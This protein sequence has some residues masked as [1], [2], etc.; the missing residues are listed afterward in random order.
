MKQLTSISGLIKVKPAALLLVIIMA[1]T[2]FSGISMGQLSLEEDIIINKPAEIPVFS[3]DIPPVLDNVN[4][5]EQTT[6]EGPDILSEESTSEKSD[7][8][9]ER[10]Y[11]SHIDESG[12]LVTTW[13]YVEIEKSSDDNEIPFSNPPISQFSSPDFIIQPNA[14]EGKDA[15]IREG[16][17][18]GNYGNFQ[19]LT[20]STSGDTQAL[21]EF[22]ITSAD[23]IDTNNITSVEMNIYHEGNWAGFEPWGVYQVNESWN[24]TNVTWNNQP[25]SS[26]IAENINW[27]NGGNMQWRTWN[28]TDI[29]FKW[30]NG[31]LA[32]NG[33]L[34]RR[35]DGVECSIYHKSSDSVANHPFLKISF[36]ADYWVNLAPAIQRDYGFPGASVSYSLTAENWGNLDETYDISSFNGTWPITFRDAGDTVDITE[37]FIPAGGNANFIARVDISGGA[38]PGDIEEPFIQLTSQSNTSYNITTKIW[39]QVPHSPSITDDFEGSDLGWHNQNIKNTG[40]N[41]ERGDPSSVSWAPSPHSSSNC[42]GTNL[43]LPVQMDADA[44]LVSPYMNLGAGQ[45]ILSFYQWYRFGGEWGDNGGFLEISV[46]GGNW[47]MIT[48]VTGYP[49]MNRNVGDYNTDCFYDTS[50]GWEYIECDLTLYGGNVIQ[51]RFHYAGDW[52]GYP[53]W[54]VDDAYIGP[55]PAYRTSLTP[56][57]SNSYGDLGQSIAYTMTVNNTGAND[58]TYDLSFTSSEQPWTIEFLDI[59]WNPTIT[60]G[61]VPA[62][63]TMDF[64]TVVQVDIGGSQGDINIANVKIISQND[65]TAN[66]TAFIQTQHP[67]WTEWFDGFENGWG[68]WR[69]EYVMPSNPETV[70]EVGV[71]S[72]G[73]S[74]SVYNGTNCSGTN[75]S[76]SYKMNTNF[77]LVSPFI[78]I[79]SLM[80]RLTFQNWYDMPNQDGGFVELSVNGGAWSQI[81]PDDG[82][83]YSG[84]LGVYNT[85]G[86]N[87]FSDDW[88]YEEFNL[89]QYFDQVI[90]VRFHFASEWAGGWWGWAIDDVFIGK[91]PDY[92]VGLAP[93]NQTLYGS[94]TENINFIITANNTGNNTD[95]YDL[96][97]D[98]PWPLVFRDIG[99]TMDITSISVDFMSSKEFIARVTIPGAA[100]PGQSGFANITAISQNDPGANDTVTIEAIVLVKPPWSDDME[101]GSDLWDTWDD[102]W[103][104]TWDLGVPSSIWEP[105]SAYSPINCWGTNIGSNYTDVCD[106]ALTSPMIDLTSFANANLTFWHWYDTSPG[107][108]GGWVEVSNDFGDNWNQITPNGGYPDFGWGTPLYGGNS[109]GWIQAEFD[110][111]A[112]AGDIISIRFYFR[113]A[114]FDGNVEYVGWY[115]DDIN[116][117][118]SA[119][120]VDISPNLIG[121]LGNPGDTIEYNLTVTNSGVVSDSFDLS[122]SGNIWTTQIYDS[123]GLTVISNTGPLTSNESIDIVVKVDIPGG[124]NPGEFDLALIKATSDNDTL[125]SDTSEI[126]TNVIALPPWFD[127]M[128]SGPG[129]WKADDNAM[130]TAWEHGDPTAFA[131]GP[132]AAYSPTNCWGTNLLSNYSSGGEA[133]LT[134]PVFNISGYNI[135]F[136][137]FWHWYDING[138]WNDGGRVEISSNYGASWSNLWPN[139]GYTDANFLG[140]GCYA[141][142]SDGWV[143]VEFDLTGWLGSEIMFRFKFIDNSGD[144]IECAG[145]YIDNVLLHVTNY[146]FDLNPSSSLRIGQPSTTVEFNMNLYV[147][148]V[149]DSYDL[150]VNGNAWTTT[151]YDQSGTIVISNTGPLSAGQWLYFLVRVDIPGGAVIND[152]DIGYLTATSDNDT[153]VSDISELKTIVP[154]VPPWFDDVESG[155]GLWDKWDS[156]DGTEWELGNPSGGT[157]P[158]G[159]YSPINC[160][161]TNILTDYTTNGEAIL[162]SPVFD[163]STLAYA[164]LSFWHWYDIHGG[165]NDGGWVEISTDDNNWWQIEPVGGYPDN[166]NVGYECYAG[167]SGGWVKAEFDLSPWAHQP[168]MIRFHFLDSSFDGT[169][170]SGWYIDDVNIFAADYQMSIYP[171]GNSLFLGYPSEIIEIPYVVTNEATEDDSY[172]LSISGNAWP[173]EIYDP[174]GTFIISNTGPVLGL[175]QMDFILKVTVPVGAVVRDLD[176]VTVFAASDNVSLSRSYTVEVHV[177]MSP[178]FFDDMESGM[179]IW[180]TWDNT[181]GTAWELGNPSPWGPSDSYSPTNCWGTNIDANYTTWG[182]CWFETPYLD[183]RGFTKANLTFWHWYD[184]NGGGNDGGWVEFRTS[185]SSW[186][187]TSPEGD[188]P[189]NHAWWYPAF[190]GTTG[191][192]EKVEFNMSSFDQ[193]VKIRFRF[194][195]W[196]GDGIERPGWYIDDIRVNVDGP[197]TIISTV[198]TDTATGVSISQDISVIYTRTMDTGI[199]PI[200]SQNSVPDPGGWIFQ[201]WSSTFLTDDTATWSHNDWNLGQDIEMQISGGQDLDAETP[202]TYFWNFT[203]TLVLSTA[204]AT[205]PTGTSNVAGITITYATGGGPASADIYYTTSTAAPYIWNLI[206]TDSPADGNYGWVIPADGTYGWIAVSPDEPAPTNADPPEASSYVYDSTS[207]TSSVD[208][209][210]LEFYNTSP[211]GITAAANDGLSGIDYVELWYSFDG[212]SY[213]LFGTDND[214]AP[215]DWNFNWPGEGHYEFYSIAVDDAGNSEA[216]PVAE[217][218]DANYDIT[219]PTIIVTAPVDL[220]VDI[221]INLPIVITFDE[222]IDDST[223]EFS[224]NPDPGGW[225]ELWNA[226]NEQVT[227]TH[228]SFALN[229]VYTLTV[230]W[231]NDTAGNPLATGLAPNPW[232]FTTELTDTQP[233]VVE[234]VSPTGIT[235]L[236]SSNIVITFNESMN[237]TSVESSI[238]IV[239]PISYTVSWSADNRTITIIPD[240]EFPYS[241]SYNVKIINTAKDMNENPMASDYS[242]DFITADPPPV[243][244]TPPVSSIEGLGAYQNTLT[245]NV[246]WTSYD[247]SDIKIVELYYTTDEGTTWTKYGTN[248][249][250]SP[251]SFTASTEGTYGFY[252]VATDNS[253]NENKEAMPASGDSPMASTYVDIT[254]PTVDVGEDVSATVM[255]TLNANTTDSGSGIS[256]YQ[257][258]MISGSGTI[259]FSSANAEDT[260]ISATVDGTYIIRLTVTDN[261][262]NIAYDEF[263]LSW[264]ATAPAATIMPTGTTVSALTNITVTFSEPVDQTLAEGAFSISPSVSGAF[265]WNADGTIMTFTPTDSL[266]YDTVYEITILA[267]NVLDLAGNPMQSNLVHSFTTASEVASF[268]ETGN[269]TGSVLDEDG[270]G[271]SGA[272][273]TLAGTTHT[274]ITGADGNYSFIDIPTGD[275]TLTIEHEDFRTSSTEISILPDQTTTVEPIILEP[276]S[277]LSEWL[278]LIIVIIAVTGLV[279]GIAIQRSR[280]KEQDDEEVEESLP[281]QT[282]VTKAAAHVPPP[283]VEKVMPTPE[284][285]T[286]DCP[287]C[288]MMIEPGMTICPMC[289]AQ[290]N[291]VQGEVKDPES[292]RTP[293]ETPKQPEKPEQP[294]IQEASKPEPAK[295]ATASPLTTEQKIANLEKAFKEGRID[296]ETYEKN[297]KL[298]NG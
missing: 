104:T 162:T 165:W 172:S 84:N 38:S 127:D 63:T 255:F 123:G 167:T 85:D 197:P 187:H 33:L 183:F 70:W 178:E 143:E 248:F 27:Y 100:T 153:F 237:T 272:T 207:P 61:P 236:V 23:F 35:A 75:I 192:W 293:S 87:G 29:F 4:E 12:E 235:A 240:N 145:W 269:I 86:Y 110:L 232:L 169:T 164:N 254:A 26:N 52:G 102:G 88:E 218:E 16:S 217:D 230:T 138:N 79:D 282:P 275:Y 24:E 31:T 91:L 298:F 71:P 182:D 81:W 177:P 108:D 57:I 5:I 39:I 11:S 289:D 37:V 279:V 163:I 139:D 243:D 202:E 51:I 130:G 291:E 244:T 175:N 53:G 36:S 8:I 260:N 101:S 294:P 209:I 229:Q 176:Q 231:A 225:N 133:T 40:T 221:S 214:G 82:Y 15:M 74:P 13:E 264:D 174:T 119:C 49:G 270:N 190:A 262:G 171:S 184:I 223:W 95:T 285:E 121:N 114:P 154:V 276:D 157:G 212:N 20:W 247:P 10:Y 261:A 215:Y 205:G 42:W 280:K 241:S 28:I 204:T 132:G 152:F 105:A 1:G 292:V 137:K 278:W 120:G 166:H 234:A 17:P 64:I 220:D 111:S 203:V 65:T 47:N 69:N 3:D 257:W 146:S 227:L 213:I 122:C 179:G 173:A 25:E 50:P 245:F 249:S 150:A 196:A 21:I 297:L 233:P 149:N 290:V 48:P 129:S 195:D 188:Y 80:S 186:Y 77:V 62:G 93:D 168:I 116:V 242:W 115:I 142:T 267:S 271:I 211:L 287:S 103:G 67:I 226:T 96:S 14:T 265:Q 206:G 83:P 131:Y 55:L 89:N 126:N 30:K 189:D 41:W 296:K 56:E 78:K 54:Y 156:G 268:V 200:L 219:S 76:G 90:Q 155:T 2:V 273:V 144:G 140:Q 135:A 256:S 98:C 246:P 107:Y 43:V 295:P 201:S 238:Q 68:A 185:S 7:V 228:A 253:A 19:E 250:A 181:G 224:C 60:V 128:E 193:P 45:Q 125:F 148:S 284:P 112:Y 258:T 106:L 22:N 124:A 239:P 147:G 198:P 160:W 99:D 73:R 113:D 222:P 277:G 18:D 216:I 32:N 44:C 281:E 170:E 259:T 288:G 97:H 109:S 46:N 6:Q 210:P 283:P 136:L 72:G 274:T 134:S 151:I 92:R 159:A 118:A 194:F 9:M 117:S 266:T 59:G 286:L 252:I 94:A 66:D 141:G 180:D 251:I 161:G 34:L 208:E 191:G 199:I 158:P 58:D 263:T